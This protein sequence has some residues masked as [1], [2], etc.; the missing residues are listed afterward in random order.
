MIT[1]IPLSGVEFLFQEKKKDKAVRVIY[2]TIH[3]K[4]GAGMQWPFRV[5]NVGIVPSY[6]LSVSVK[7][8]G[9]RDEMLILKAYNIK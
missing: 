9:S 4:T 8:I 7:G 1:A 3:S 6:S 2:L 5:R